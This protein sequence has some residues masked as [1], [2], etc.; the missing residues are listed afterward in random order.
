MRGCPRSLLP[1]CDWHDS[2]TERLCR[3]AQN[4]ADVPWAL[5]T[6]PRTRET[7]SRRRCRAS[8]SPVGA[9]PPADPLLP[10]LCATVDVAHSTERMLWRDASRRCAAHCTAPLSCSRPSRPS[11]LVDGESGSAGS[12]V[13]RRGFGPP[14]RASTKVQ[15]R[16]QARCVFD[17]VALNWAAGGWWKGGSGGA[18]AACARSTAS[19]VARGSAWHGRCARSPGRPRERGGGLGAP[20]TSPGRSRGVPAPRPWRLRPAAG[21][22]H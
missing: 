10:M 8:H 4:R 3:T 9:P 1:D 11:P 7:P 15:V 17:R 21:P 22:A 5:W 6:P 20:V 14:S 13:G 18:C 2:L 16:S 12:G 19:S